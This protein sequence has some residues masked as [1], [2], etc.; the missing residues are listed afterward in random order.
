MMEPQSYADKI[1]RRIVELELAPEPHAVDDTLKL[2]LL[3][4]VL[5]DLR[6]G[7]IDDSEAKSRIEDGATIYFDR[8][9]EQTNGKKKRRKAKGADDDKKQ[10]R[11]Q[12]DIL[13]ELATNGATLFHS[14][15]STPFADIQVN[16]HRETFPIRSK[17][18][19]RWLA[20]R[21]FETQ[22]GAPSSEAMSSALNVI[23]AKAYFDG[24]EIEVCVRI[25]VHDGSIY[26]DLGDSSWSAVEV[27]ASG[28][29]IVKTPPV[30]FRRSSGM[31]SLPR[32]KQGGTIETLRDFLNVRGSDDI[33]LA[34]SWLLAA[35]RDCGPYPVLVLSG[36]QGAAK[37]T[38]SAILRSLIDPNTAPLR[39]LPREDRDL[40]IAANNGRVLAFDN[41]S[42]LQ[43]WISDTLCRLATGGGFSVRQ[44][45]S[46]QDE[47]LFDA[48]RPI[49]L[50]GITDIVT[51]PDLADR[52]IFLS[53][54]AIPEAKRKAEK[55]LWADFNAERPLILGALLDAIAVGLTML[56]H[57]RLAKLP[58]M[59]DF[60]L[61]ATACESAYTDE[62]TFSAAYDANRSE[63]ID[64]VIEGDT[65]GSAIRDLMDELAEWEGTAAEL[66]TALEDKA[67]DRT[68]NSK[69][70]PK[71]ARSLSG[72]LRRA[73]TFLR[74]KDIDISF[75]REG[76]K[77]TRTIQI[78]K[79]APD[80]LF[81]D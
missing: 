36:E 81:A 64:S 62:G 60:A 4:D 27:D 30:R 31:Q 12:A 42:G 28:W 32:P 54:E 39:A 52:A 14:P 75:R 61:W 47:I 45:Y 20:R 72:Q 59:A 56:P 57:T 18:F 71:S 73:A 78:Q 10:Q 19:K 69:Q 13:I 35:F 34:V 80:D 49:I 7:Q 51:R 17:G 77:R 67:D 70:W 65:V 43:P 29:R 41:C 53:L 63:A 5:S 40:F 21:F 33:T 76:K 74:Q 50:N 37:S 26:L 79:G 22:N 68:R 2:A 38:F 66:L 8:E 48:Q 11:K 44:L 16:G 6:N 25:G 58:R 1:Q 3:E 46:D 15:D 24:S 55:E 9:A 23:E